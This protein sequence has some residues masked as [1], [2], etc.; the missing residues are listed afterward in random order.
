MLMRRYTDL[1]NENKD[2]RKSLTANLDKLIQLESAV[3]QHRRT[4]EEGE[5]RNNRRLLDSEGEIK[6]LS[7]RIDRNGRTEAESK[8]VGNAEIQLMQARLSSLSEE[9]RMTVEN[10]KR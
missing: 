8:V 9:I 10:G 5:S 7:R 2:L 4:F 3:G 6:E 1:E